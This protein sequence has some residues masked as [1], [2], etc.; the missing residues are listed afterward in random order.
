MIIK[1]H[2][3]YIMHLTQ[4]KNGNLVSLGADAYINI[5]SLLDN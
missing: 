2:S 4:L 1:E 5:Y 3:N